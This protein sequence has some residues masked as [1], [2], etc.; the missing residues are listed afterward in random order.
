MQSVVSRPWGGGHQMV[1]NL[2]VGP[3]EPE[4]RFIIWWYEI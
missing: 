4:A 1:K 2:V 3:F